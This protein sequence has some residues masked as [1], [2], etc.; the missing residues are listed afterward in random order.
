MD[1]TA[2]G[3]PA[4]PTAPGAPAGGNFGFNFSGL[5]SVVL[6]SVAS[7]VISLLAVLLA[8]NWARGDFG[9]LATVVA[10]ACA[11][12]FFVW[13]PEEAKGTLRTVITSVGPA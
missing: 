3:A 13:F 9:K 7:V 11:V 5:E 8:L 12:L 10:G 6:E 2:P 1:E 4:A